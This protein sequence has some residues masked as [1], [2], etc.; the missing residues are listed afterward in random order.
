LAAVEFGEQLADAPCLVELRVEPGVVDL[1]E[2]PLGPGVEVDVG[3]GEAAALVVSEAEPAELAPEVD[4]VGF[5]AGARMGAGLNRVLLRGQ[6]ERVETQGVQNIAAGHPEVAR[7]DV[8]R[9]VAQGV[10]DVQSLAR[11]I[12]EHVLDEHLVRRYGAAVGGRQRADG[13]RHVE[14]APTLPVALPLLFD[15]AGQFRGVAV[16]RYICAAVGAVRGGSRRFGHGRQGIGAPLEPT[17]PEERHI[18]PR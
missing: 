13:V 6:A 2:D 12:R 11:G 4:D 10:S 5:G 17:T 14:G 8:G 18:E 1:Q 16:P 7:V 15:A 3:G 9:D